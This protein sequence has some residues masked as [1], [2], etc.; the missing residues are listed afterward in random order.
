MDAGYKQGSYIENNAK[1]FAFFDL[2]SLMSCVPLYRAEVHLC[3][4]LANR[5][6]YEMIMSVKER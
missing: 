3:S 5:A 4:F 2:Q 6:R 1:K